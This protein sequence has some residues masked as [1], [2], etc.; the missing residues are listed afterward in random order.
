MAK[1]KIIMLFEFKKK[2]TLR[3]ISM[4]ENKPN[5]YEQSLKKNGKNTKKKR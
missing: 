4:F 1:D 3:E 2:S 5:K